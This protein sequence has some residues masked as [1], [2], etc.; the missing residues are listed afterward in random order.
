MIEI[1][2]KLFHEAGYIVEEIQPEFESNIEHLSFFA[3]VTKEDRFDFFLVIE[4]KEVKIVE[5]ILQKVVDK[6]FEYIVETNH[7][8][9]ID[10]NLSLLILLQEDSVQLENKLNTFVYDLEE[11]PYDFKKYVLSYTKEQFSLVEKQIKNEDSFTNVFQQ[12]IQNKEMFSE[13]KSPSNK[14]ACLIYDLISK[15]FIKLHFLTMEIDTLK[16]SNLENEI[17]N[18]LTV[19]QLEIRDK[20]IS[21][22]SKDEMNLELLLEKLEVVEEGE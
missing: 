11:D 2:K 10:K 6:Y 20:I 4:L 21:F 8:Q 5:S 3:K 13:F 22:E 1:I 18:E 19:Y 7:E 16:L 14:E 17:E 15:C 9:G 12:I